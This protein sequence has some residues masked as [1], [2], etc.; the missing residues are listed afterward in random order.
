ME[1]LFKG[2]VIKKDQYQLDDLKAMV[3]DLEKKYPSIIDKPTKL[4]KELGYGDEY[5]YAHNE[6]GAFAAG[7]NYF[8]EEIKDRQ[9]YLPSER[10]LEKQIKDKLE[11]LRSLNQMGANKR[12]S[13]D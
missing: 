6:E 2:T 7:E 9:Y 3:E 10:G 13:N 5:R 1:I 4:M 8:P 11:Y 12:Y